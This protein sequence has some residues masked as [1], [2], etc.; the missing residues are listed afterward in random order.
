M[1]LDPPGTCSCAEGW[2][3]IKI[4]FPLLLSPAGCMSGHF[5]KKRVLCLQLSVTHGHTQSMAQANT[6]CATGLHT[7]LIGSTLNYPKSMLHI[8]G[9]GLALPQLCLP[10]LLVPD[11]QQMDPNSSSC[12]LEYIACLIAQREG[13]QRE[14]SSKGS[15]RLQE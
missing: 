6:P 12:L 8:R 7:E 10:L 3:N 14:V 11:R 2:R 15:W 9:C 5:T 1:H 4:N 13:E